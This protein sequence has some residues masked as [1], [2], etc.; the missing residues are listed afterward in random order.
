MNVLVKLGLNL[1]N[2]RAAIKR[3]IGNT[4]DE[5]VS[6]PYAPRT[7]SVLQAAKDEANALHHTHIGTEHILLGLLHESE[8]P[9]AEIFKKF[10]V[11]TAQLRKEILKELNP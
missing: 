6:I 8:G 10:Q 2:V 5:K 11:D 7:K 3:G 4:P 9:A 1:E